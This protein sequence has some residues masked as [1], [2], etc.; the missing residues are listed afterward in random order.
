M[1]VGDP[2]A[3]KIEHRIKELNAI[4]GEYRAEVDEAEAQFK[5]RKITK[6]EFERVKSKCDEKMDHINDKVKVCHD[7]LHAMRDKK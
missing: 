4:R 7:E 1:I 2:K 3:E 5:K 6:E